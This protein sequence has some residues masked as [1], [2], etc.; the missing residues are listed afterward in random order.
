METAAATITTTSRQSFFIGSSLITDIWAAHCNAFRITRRRGLRSSDLKECYL[1]AG[2]N[3][4]NRAKRD[5]HDHLRHCS[6]D[7]HV[8]DIPAPL[9]QL[10]RPLVWLA[11]N[12]ALGFANLLDLSF[13]RL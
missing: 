12:V 9:P 4:R 10:M 3:Y 6:L 5:G 7:L 8:I 2:D 11:A 13:N 1:G